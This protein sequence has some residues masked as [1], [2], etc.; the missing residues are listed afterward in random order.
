MPEGLKP[1]YLKK[2]DDRGETQI[3]AVDGAYVRGHTDE[4]FTNFGQYFYD[5]C[6]SGLCLKSSLISA[7]NPGQIACLPIFY[8]SCYDV[9]DLTEKGSRD[10]CEKSLRYYC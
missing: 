8:V 4:E 2:I 7:A 3:W 9:Y 1:P 6:R 10:R 5:D